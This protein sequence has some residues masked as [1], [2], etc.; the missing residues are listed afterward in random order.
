M[1]FTG[2]VGNDELYTLVEAEARTKRKVATWRKDIRLRKVP[3]VKIGRQ[4][5]IP[6]AFLDDMIQ[7]GWRNPIEAECDH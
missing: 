1:R 5:R 2:Q 4:V 7:Q 3:Y 6:K